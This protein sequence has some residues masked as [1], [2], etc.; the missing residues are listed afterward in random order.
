MNLL[1]ICCK[2]YIVSFY[3]ILETFLDSIDSIDS[4]DNMDNIDSNILFR[5]SYIFFSS[6]KY[7]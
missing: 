4:I 5:N 2:F 1:I 7:I 6:Y 3:Y